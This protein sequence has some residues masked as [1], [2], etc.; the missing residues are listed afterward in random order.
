MEKTPILICYDGSPG[1]ARAID[2]AAR[3]LGPRH[4]VVLDVAPPITTAESLAT[5]SPVVAG[6][7]FEEMN[8]ADAKSVAGR[9]AELARSAGFEAE[10]RGGIGGPTWDE[11]V[12][13]ADEANASVIVIGSRGLSGMREVLEGSL[14]HEVAEHAGRPVLIV[15]PA[16]GKQ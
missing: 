9:G 8:I 3:L 4:A 11:V 12:Y 2:A 16:H 10:A 13:A 1:A 15:P 7:E 5:L 14:S 6:A